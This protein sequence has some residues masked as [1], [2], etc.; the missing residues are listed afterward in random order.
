MPID[1]IDQIISQF[2]TPPDALLDTP[3]EFSNKA[4]AFVAHQAAAYVQQVNAWAVEANALGVSINDYIA[5]L[6]AGAINDAVVG[7]TTTFSSEKLLA[8]QPNPSLIINGNMLINQ[9]DFSGAWVDGEYAYDRWKATATAMTQII[10]DGSYK[11][12]TEY[13]LSG[14]GVT[15]VQ[16]TSPA[17]GHWTLPE[18]P[19][20]VT[21]VKLELGSV[22]TPYQARP[23][24]EELALCQRYFKIL[25]VIGG[26][27]P[28]E[29]KINVGADGWGQMRIQPTASAGEIHRFSIGNYNITSWEIGSSY[30]DF[31][32][33][34]DLGGDYS[35]SG[36]T[37]VRLNAE[38]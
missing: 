21:M 24:G 3:E 23:I 20:T 12:S 4:D 35:T 33:A 37:N 38:L 1:P 32:C 5:S 13:T 31:G 26:K 34:E 6:P 28:G 14:T 36:I 19:R 25:N 8:I 30:G 18:I 2:P 16:I 27:R 10:E 9:R 11:P 22:A 29:N 15:T 17:S 7:L